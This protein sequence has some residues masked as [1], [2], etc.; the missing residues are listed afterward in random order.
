MKLFC[1]LLSLVMAQQAWGQAPGYYQFP[2]KPGQQNF[3]SGTMGELRS[4][5]FHAGIDI[6]TE[7]RE[8]LSVHAAAEGYV[9]RIRVSA[10][11]YGKVIYLQHPN[12][13]RTVYGHLQTFHKDL[14]DYV[15]EAQYQQEKFEVDLYPPEGKFFFK[16]GEVIALSGNTG[17]SGGPH[18][19]FEIR[20][21]QDV[22]MD[23]LAYQFPEIKDR[24][25]PTVTKIAFRALDQHSRV[26][27]EFGRVEKTVLRTGNTYRM[28][29]ELRAYGN[30][31][32]EFQGKDLADGT[33]NSYGINQ[34][35]IRKNGEI[36]YA[37]QIERIPFEVTRQIN[38]FKDYQQW[39]ENKRL[40]QKCYQEPGNSLPFYEDSPGRGNIWVEEEETANLVITL[41]DTYGNRAEVLVKVN[42]QKTTPAT[43][44]SAVQLPKVYRNTLAMT[45]PSPSVGVY[46]GEYA[47]YPT[48]SYRKNKQYVYLWDLTQGIPD[49]VVYGQKVE[50]GILAQVFYPTSSATLFHELADIHI[51][52]SAIHDTLYLALKQQDQTLHIGDAHIPLF[53]P[54][55]I[56]INQPGQWGIRDK[57]HAYLHE[58]TGKHTFL[59][60]EWDSGAFIFQTQEFGRMV[61]L[62]DKVPPTIQLVSQTPREVS[63]LIKDERSGIAGYRATLDG[64]WLLM[65]YDP[66]KDLIWSELPKTKKNLAGLFELTVTD[67]AGNTK[68]YSRSF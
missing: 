27:G 3:L 1:L 35:V 67:K 62:E 26:E 48:H 55:S 2:I 22:V 24:V 12:K 46:L 58:R 11:G 41:T 19:H 49:S 13:T 60:G 23:P 47:H 53:K 32:F 45:F 31:G 30:I 63:L 28:P 20:D 56:R 40:F 25:A 9:Y 39:K 7:G 18:L 42:G 4:N 51:P 36:I 5:H 10:R 59:G 66:R 21:Q 44:A 29:G 43:E 8:G 6:K 65:H 54:I 16:R 52:D 38:L 64:E 34:V 57:V 14:N 17:S 50:R 15:L 61:F 33:T 37:H 68:T